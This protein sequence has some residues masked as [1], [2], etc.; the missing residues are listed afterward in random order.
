MEYTTSDQPCDICGAVGYE[1]VLSTCSNCQKSHEH[2]YCMRNL[3]KK[4]P[5]EW[6][7]EACQLQSVVKGCQ[8]VIEDQVVPISGSL[9]QL[10][11]VSMQC[12]NHIGLT[13]HAVKE[14]L[15][16]PRLLGWHESAGK[17]ISVKPNGYACKEEAA[18]A[19]PAHE[20][21]RSKSQ[22]LS[23][24]CEN[25]GN[26][27]AI[28]A[29]WKGSFDIP[30]RISPFRFCE[31]F[32]AHTPCKVSRK[33][34]EFAK[35]M[36]GK[37]KFQLRPRSN[38]LPEMFYTYPPTMDDVALFFFPGDFNRSQEKYESLLELLEKHDYVITS[39][40]GSV[41]LLVLTSKHLQV[42][43][44]ML[45][46]QFFLWGL[47]R[48][49]RRHISNI[50]IESAVAPLRS[51]NGRD[52]NSINVHDD[53]EMDVEIDILEGV[54]VGEVEKVMQCNSHGVKKVHFP[55]E[56]DKRKLVITNALHR[57]NGC[58][59]GVIEIKRTRIKQPL[60]E[61]KE[62]CDDLDSPPGFSR[63]ITSYDT[64][65]GELHGYLLPKPDGDGVPPRI[66]NPQDA[67]RLKH[68]EVSF[69]QIKKMETNVTPKKAEV[70]S[71]SENSSLE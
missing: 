64:T 2:I 69:I 11:P 47:F 29:I 9:E 60:R 58:D 28:D 21:K 46:M 55:L 61:V 24:S 7:C 26:Y 17:E 31:G 62:E 45:N 38:V 66:E 48:F 33:A 27:P 34:Y 1:E 35:E 44:Q 12:L 20:V 6:S 13:D 57:S 59:S 42:D 18:E 4:M 51:I 3:T 30:D 65:S 54:D 41:E 40:L 63:L 53:P 8:V 5:E 71:A 23:R 43:S 15:E 37:L 52:L 16:E 68:V 50:R 56:R 67:I 14:K 32:W 39:C 22:I 70:G 25:L 36:P 10:Q 19:L 49:M